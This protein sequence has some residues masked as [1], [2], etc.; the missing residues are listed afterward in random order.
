MNIRMLFLVS[1]GLAASF[2]LAM[3]DTSNDE[4]LAR[5]LQ[6]QDFLSEQVSS[7]STNQLS[8]RTQLAED[9]ELMIAQALSAAID[10][11]AP[12]SVN[13]T[14][15]PASVMP[16]PAAIMHNDDDGLALALQLSMQEALENKTSTTSTAQNSKLSKQEDVKPSVPV[17]NNS[18][19][20]TTA[21]TAQKME[22]CVCGDEKPSNE[23][24]LAF[25]PTER[26]S[27]LAYIASDKNITN[28]D[29]TMAARTKTCQH[30]LCKECKQ[31]LQRGYT[32]EG[33]TFNVPRENGASDLVIND[34]IN[35]LIKV[36]CP[37][38]N[39]RTRTAKK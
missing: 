16:K 12:R 25:T 35:Y 10:P 26:T 29:K 36:F 6:E 24:V 17:K 37:V 30:T 9:E 39:I 23:F 5:A 11:Q 18:T 38:C 2:A 8:N 13:R 19:T 4:E 27:V 34:S 1:F 20:S 7:R 31:K 22:C 3:E 32:P 33:E 15:A 14:P 28:F 21:T